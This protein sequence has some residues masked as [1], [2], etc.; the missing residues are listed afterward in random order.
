[1]PIYEY[2]CQNCG[3]QLEVMQ[4]IDDPA[5]SSCP[6]CQTEAP[7]ERLVSRSSFHLKGGGW[8]SDLYGSKKDGTPAASSPSS[9]GTAAPPSATTTP[10]TP[11]AQKPAA[12]PTAAP[13]TTPAAAPAAS[14]GGGGKTS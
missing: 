6:N 13:V 8:Y 1:M 5:P 14:T 2:R 10:T 12:A 4:K 3:H 11:E 9:N 7:L